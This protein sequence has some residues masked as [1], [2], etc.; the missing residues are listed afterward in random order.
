MLT[1][2]LD[3]IYHSVIMSLGIKY[4][5]KGELVVPKGKDVL[6]H[7][8]FN[9]KKIAI[10]TADEIETLVKFVALVKTRQV[11]GVTARRKRMDKA[12]RVKKALALKGKGMT[13]KQI[14]EKI[15]AST[16]T[17]TRDLKSGK[18]E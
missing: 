3:S 7:I 17:V 13:V 2:S 6:F 14:A 4:S 15:G 10:T 1:A 12:S 5:M 16:M 8:L 11:N 9:G 18:K